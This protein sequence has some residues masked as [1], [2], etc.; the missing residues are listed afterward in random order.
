MD[1]G[2]GWSHVDQGGQV[3]KGNVPTPSPKSST[4]PLK[5]P[6]VK[7]T[8]KEAKPAK[9]EPKPTPATMTAAVKPKTPAIAG[10]NSAVAVQLAT[11]PHPTK[12]PLEGITG[13]VESLP[14]DACVEL[15]CRLLTFLSSLP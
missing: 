5:K 15:T 4:E 2:E 3:V 6:K 12:C 7:V 10:A 9:T 8:R 11:V 13:H 1:L 14:L